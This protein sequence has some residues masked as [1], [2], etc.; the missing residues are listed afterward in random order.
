MHKPLQEIKIQGEALGIDQTKTIVCPFCFETWMKQ[1]KPSEWSPEKSCSITRSY[2]GYLYICFRATCSKQGIVRSP[3]C[4]PIATTKTHK[5]V[6]FT[7]TNPLVTVPTFVWESMLKPYG[8]SKADCISQHIQWDVKAQRVY[9]PV[10]NRMGHVIGGVGKAIA[11]SQ[12]PKTLTYRNNDV[13]MLHY[14]LKQDITQSLVL[15][16]DIISSI[17]VSKVAPCAALLGSNITKPILKQVLNDGVTDV[18][19]MLDGDVGKKGIEIKSK[20][21]ALFLNFSL[22]QL[23]KDK[24]PKDLALKELKELIL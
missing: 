24:D 14:P 13:P 23:S 11:H 5:F 4:K 10:F 2:I 1:G 8:V 9:M 16:E 3:V 21:G 15:V 18:T 17:K 6:S 12:K 22:V 7:N 20:V 19:L